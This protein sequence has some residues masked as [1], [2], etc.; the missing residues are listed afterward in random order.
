[1]TVFRGTTTY[2]EG[3]ALA[4]G[5]GDADALGPDRFTGVGWGPPGERFLKTG[6]RGGRPLARR[7]ELVHDRSSGVRALTII[8]PRM[9]RASVEAKRARIAK[10]VRKTGKKRSIILKLSVLSRDAP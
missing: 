1:M 2:V 8:V 3:A 6:A 10:A 5:D 9:G 4:D 7:L